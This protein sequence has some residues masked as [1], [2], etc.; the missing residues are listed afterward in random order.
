M[1]TSLQ[2]LAGR[3][4]SAQYVLDSVELKTVYLACRMEKPILLEGP[5][6]CGKTALGNAIAAAAATEVVRLQCYPGITADKAIG[7]FDAALQEL[8][9]KTR[10]AT[11]DDGWAAMC[12]RL[13]SMEFFSPGPLMQA[14]VATRRKVLLIDEVDKVDDAFEAFLLEVLSE[15]QLSVPKLG[16][17]R[18]ATKPVVVLTSNESRRLGDPLRRRSL[19]LR[20]DYP[21]IARETR[22]LALRS[23]ISDPEL[24]RFIAGF[25][26]ALRAWR[27]EKPPS[28]AEIVEFEQALALLSIVEITS[29]MRDELLPLIAKTAEDRERLQIRNGFEKLI[30]DARRN[31]R[32]LCDEATGKELEEAEA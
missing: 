26:Q 30:S 7:Q 14:I 4:E 13:H 11:A 5:P 27:M 12:Q 2:D 15:W 24:R 21:S 28:I 18:H 6:G 9:L 20:M 19:Y 29:D 16:T 31:A 17:I 25:A 22:I 8:F 1:F 23:K 10:P 3:L 32:V